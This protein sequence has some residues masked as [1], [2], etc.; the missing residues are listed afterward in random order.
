MNLPL[1]PQHKVF[2]KD[3]GTWDAEVEVR[4]A[5]GA[6]VQASR[7]VSVNRLI[8]GGAWLVADYV[9][10]SGFEGHGVYGF[11]QTKNSYVGTWVDSMRRFLVIAEGDWDEANKRMTYRGEA[12]MPDGR[13]LR[14]R[15]ETTTLDRDTQ[16]FRSFMALPDGSDF[17]MMTVKYRRR[18]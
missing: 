18:P 16:V 14:W 13:V 6:P 10:D 9:A 17:E 12:K 3:V 1:A 5:P 7:G 15:E 4:P 8:A 11:D 2:E